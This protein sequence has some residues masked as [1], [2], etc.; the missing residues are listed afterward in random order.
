MAT[1][2]FAASEGAGFIV[3]PLFFW[4]KYKETMYRLAKTLSSLIFLVFPEVW[5]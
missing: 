1:G 4:F 3:N 2:I 5:R